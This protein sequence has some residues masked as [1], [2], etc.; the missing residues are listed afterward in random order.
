MIN[1]NP[2]AI[3]A[4]ISAAVNTF[5][6]ESLAP[7]AFGRIETNN[8]SVSTAAGQAD[9]ATGLAATDG[10]R[11]E[12]GS[13]TKMM[14]ATVLLQLVGEGKINLDDLASKYL[15]AD[16]IKGIANAD[17]ATVRQLA[18]MTSG[19]ANYTDVIGPNGQPAFVE[20]ILSNPDKVFA[21][22]DALDIT[23]GQPA[24]AAPGAFNYSNTN[25]NLL[26]ALIENVTQEP[27]AKTFETRIFTPAG[28]AQSDL[29]GAQAPAD[30][31]RGF[32]TGPD[33]K[34]LD[35]TNALWDK[36]SEG[37]VV[38]TSADMIKYIKALLVEGKL[39]Q[40]AQLAEMKNFLVVGDTPELK[41]NFGLGLVE[42]EI[43]GQGKYFGFNGTTLGF[44][45]ATYLSAETGAIA[46][47][48]L[49]YADTAVPAEEGVLRLL[50]TQSDNTKD[51][52][53]V[54]KFDAK[55]DVLNVQSV[56][57]ASATIDESGDF[58]VKFG[59]VTL[60]LPL[61]LG[62]VTT[63]NV[64][65]DDGSVLVVGDNQ[66][67]TNRDGRS[68]LIDILKTFREAANED[69]QI[70]GLGGDDYLS[71]GNGND[72]ISGGSG[73]DFLNGRNGNDTLLGGNGNDVLE[74]RIGND[75]LE[76]GAG[77]DYLFGG[78]GAD[79]FIFTNLADSAIGRNARDV[80]GDFKRG[81]DKIS[82]S[83]IDAN[84]T[85]DLD[86]SFTF[87]GASAF[88]GKAGELHTFTNRGQ[89][90]VEGDV[91]GDGKADFQ[92]ELGGR[93]AMDPFDFIL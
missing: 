83:A 14:T 9:P 55:S 88:S 22:G 57:A 56:S 47:A 18:Q 34:L 51:W 90:I 1:F 87:I 2:V 69:N 50:K 33:G 44:V 7:A 79:T 62:A 42:F 61:K 46:T 91:N 43:P 4:P 82:L 84:T 19:I 21:P 41:F 5:Q 73:D 77:R 80:I 53:S 40:P 58:N 59:D 38:S 86:Q 63:S 35:T 66:V 64:K 8:V 17:I 76:G 31:V 54:S 67:G 71:G 60:K 93:Y 92:I 68:N 29:I 37:G 65:F 30:L 25:Y 85:L 3:A 23:R 78:K 13:Q 20:L 48:A 10:Q 74:G 36:F 15:P 89:T 24:I 52:T 32:G 72:K 16:T 49:N 28:M 75:V 39:L 26:G 45:S 6:T 11:F 12:I 70:L 81:E 27:L